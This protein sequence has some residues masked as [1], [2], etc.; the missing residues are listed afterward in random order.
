MKGQGGTKYCEMLKNIKPLILFRSCCW[1]RK[2]Q[3]SLDHPPLLW[4]KAWNAPLSPLIP[5]RRRISLKA[6]SSSCMW[7]QREKCRVF[8]RFHCRDWFR[9]FSHRIRW[10]L[11]FGFFLFQSIS[12]VEQRV[13]FTEI[14]MAW[15]KECL[16]NTLELLY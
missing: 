7:R 12:F 4:R 9:I 16:C 11:C 3:N 8:Y 6:T 2:P 1:N 13:Q 5:I 14:K 10:K 15:S